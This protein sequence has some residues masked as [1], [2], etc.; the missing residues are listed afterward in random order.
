M[1]FLDRYRV[2][3]SVTLAV[4]VGAIV[5]GVIVTAPKETLPAPVQQTTQL[6][7]NEVPYGVLQADPRTGTVPADDIVTFTKKLEEVNS[8]VRG[9]GI[10]NTP[11]ANEQYQLLWQWGVD[12]NLQPVAYDEKGVKLFTVPALARAVRLIEI[13][14]DAGR[15]C[16]VD[17]RILSSKVN[18]DALTMSLLSDSCQAVTKK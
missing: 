12:R 6:A 8:Y 18:P 5:T 9:L 3:I 4:I 10:E 17:N 7:E 2:W 14:P 13:G 1:D 16:L 15:Y 11:E